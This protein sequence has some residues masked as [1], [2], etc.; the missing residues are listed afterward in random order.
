[1][2]EGDKRGELVVHVQ[3]TLN[4]GWCI[5]SNKNQTGKVSQST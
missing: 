3:S 5:Y 1:M 2:G 4:N